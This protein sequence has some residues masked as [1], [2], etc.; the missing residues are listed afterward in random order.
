MNKIK[1]KNFHKYLLQIIQ[2]VVSTCPVSKP[3]PPVRM[4]VLLDEPPP[5]TASCRTCID[6]FI[7]LRIEKGMMII[8]Y[9]GRISDRMRK[10]LPPHAPLCGPEVK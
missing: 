9:V 1:E 10:L 6:K 8:M 3:H 5:R 7:V 2:P 4:H